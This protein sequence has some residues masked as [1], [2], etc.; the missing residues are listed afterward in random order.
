MKV[1]K[2]NSKQHFRNETSN[3]YQI[4][5]LLPHVNF[6]AVKTLVYGWLTS[7]PYITEEEAEEIRKEAQR[8]HFIL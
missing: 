4:K 7:R 8:K 1:F 2:Q 3:V 6:V 5:L